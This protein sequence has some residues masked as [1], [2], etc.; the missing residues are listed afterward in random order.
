MAYKNK[1]KKT[2]YINTECSDWWLPQAGVGR[3]NGRS[4]SKGIN[5]LRY[6]INKSWECNVHHIDYSQTL[7]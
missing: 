6:K 2:E 5:F 4:G 3:Q 7:W 1:H